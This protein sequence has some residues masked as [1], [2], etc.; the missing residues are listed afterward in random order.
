MIAGFSERTII[1]FPNTSKGGADLVLRLNALPL[2]I[3]SDG[4]ALKT[5]RAVPVV[6]DELQP[7]MI[8]FEAEHLAAAIERLHQMANAGSFVLESGAQRLGTVH[9]ITRGEWWFSSF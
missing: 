3:A 9:L 2:T 7:S 4:T 1:C 6:R 8:E 5:F